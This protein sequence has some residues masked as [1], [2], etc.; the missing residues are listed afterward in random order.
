MRLSSLIVYGVLATAN[1]LLAHSQE[2]YQLL[3]VGA[4]AGRGYSIDIGYGKRVTNPRGTEHGADLLFSFW[5]PDYRSPIPFDKT[6]EVMADDYVAGAYWDSN[7]D[8]TLGGWT[9]TVAVQL[10]RKLTGN[11]FY[12]T[13]R[14]INVRGD[15][16]EYHQPLGRAHIGRFLQAPERTASSLF[17]TDD[18]PRIKRRILVNEYN[19]SCAYYL[20]TDI[21]LIDENLPAMIL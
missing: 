3:A 2:E 6:R 18:M 13:R 12:G 17:F 9:A 5:T 10:S 14:G 4:S 20:I 15:G 11:A 19:E 21:F 8:Y 7:K 16:L 1:L